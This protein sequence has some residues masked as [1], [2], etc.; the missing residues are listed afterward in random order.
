MKKPLVAFAL[1]TASCSFFACSTDDVQPTNHPSTGGGGNTETG[2]GGGGS[3]GVGGNGGTG[4]S[5]G[6]GGNG[7]STGGNGGGGSAGTSGGGGGN[8]GTQVVMDAAPTPSLCDGKPKKTLPYAISADFKAPTIIGAA[9]TF[10]MTP[11]P[12]CN[13]VFPSGEGGTDTSDA[14]PDAAAVDD[15]A[16]D[17][18]A[19]A[20]ASDA[21]VSDG[22]AEAAADAASAA[23]ACYEFKYDPGLCEAGVCW[24]GVI[25]QPGATPPPADA[26]VQTQSGICI[27]TG[28][29]KIDFMAR[30]SRPGARIKFGSIREGMGATE[31]FLNVTTQWAMY[32]ITIPVGEP[33]NEGAATTG[34]VWNGFSAVVEPQDHV[35]GT[36]IQIKD[37]TWKKQ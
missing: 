19:D 35:G 3:T 22:S 32:S 18:T 13:A 17:V 2:S 4:T 16:A 12:D 27:E 20:V 28:A 21:S 8:A 9:S 31:F 24:A 36:T 5:T 29:T 37:M 33:Y 34:G 7:G 10:S 30:A 6:G 15:A 11:S 26:A 23:P 14:A 1:V 25:Y